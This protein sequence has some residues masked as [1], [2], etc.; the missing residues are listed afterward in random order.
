MTLNK[1][2]FEHG[3][4]E[5]LDFYRR[6][7][8]LKFVTAVTLFTFIPLG[9]KNLLIGETLLGLSLLAFEISF[10]I[11]MFGLLYAERKIIGNGIPLSLLVISI[12]LSLY[13]LGMVASYWVYPIVVTLVFIIPRRQ[14]LITN[15]CLVAGCGIVSFHLV[16]WQLAVRF[17]SSL[18]ACASIAHVA[19]EAIHRLQIEL[20]YL[21]TRDALT[22]AL[23]RHQLDA[24]LNRSISQKKRGF[25]ASVA[26][27]DIDHFKQVNDL[28]GHDV[29][30][31]V[32]KKI[33]EVINEHTRDLDILFRL[34]GD[35]FLLLLDNTNI[36][37]AYKLLDKLCKQIRTQHYPYHA[38]ITMSVG[39]SPAFNT[40]DAVSW[41]KRA[42][43]ALYQSKENGRD[44]ITINVKS[45]AVTDD[46]ELDQKVI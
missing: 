44:Q 33:V 25:S 36:S 1:L 17:I 30:D 10:A 18:I 35:E 19:V 24:F 45:D 16:D 42:D 11:E 34:G 21:S 12:T 15:S 37:E 28:Y 8:I 20:R 14:A 7:H 5:L 4:D 3:D 27:I 26:L 6:Q 43:I 22:G 38:E 31:I 13:K 23:N 40:D 9:I 39:I 2:R 41:I 29:G 32:I 46:L